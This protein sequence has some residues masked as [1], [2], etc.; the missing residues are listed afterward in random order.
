MAAR[1]NAPDDQI[2][3]SNET[4]GHHCDPRQ[5]GTCGRPG[6]T[7]SQAAAS[8]ANRQAD[9]RTERETDG[10]KEPQDRLPHW[11]RLT[12]ATLA[13][14]EKAERRRGAHE[15]ENRHLD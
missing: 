7:S 1:K 13:L 10:T 12:E 8:S 2:A 11:T 15:G 6:K 4:D 9:G 3:D 14:T 5:P